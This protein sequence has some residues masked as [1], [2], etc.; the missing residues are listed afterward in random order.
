MTPSPPTWAMLHIPLDAATSFP[1]LNLAAAATSFLKS[2]M[3]RMITV[4]P[5]MKHQAIKTKSQMLKVV[6]PKIMP[7]KYKEKGKSR[8][9]KRKRKL[10]QNT[11]LLYD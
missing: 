3:G 1:S 10:A 4:I 9:R 11:D 2:M 6:A 5:P 7:L 8:Q